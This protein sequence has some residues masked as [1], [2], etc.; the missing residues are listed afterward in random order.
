MGHPG[1]VHE[2]SLT[3]VS[4]RPGRAGLLAS[5]MAV[6]LKNGRSHCSRYLNSCILLL[7]FTSLFEIE[8]ISNIS[9]QSPNRNTSNNQYAVH[10]S[11]TRSYARRPHNRKSC[12]REAQRNMPRGWFNSYR[13]VEEC[14]W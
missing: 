7:L 6:I 9:E 4:V 11:R 14:S 13:N 8:H 2:I 12:D 1:I 10:H 3:V 5:Q